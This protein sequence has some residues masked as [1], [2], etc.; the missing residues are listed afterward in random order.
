MPLFTPTP[1]A[2]TFAIPPS[3]V[4]IV[5]SASMTSASS[6]SVK[7]SL[8]ITPPAGT[9]AP[10]CAVPV[11]RQPHGHSVVTAVA[12]PAPQ[13]RST[14]SEAQLT[15]ASRHGSGLAGPGASKLHAAHVARAQLHRVQAMAVTWSV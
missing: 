6:G 15:D 7:S 1:D 3:S 12:S 8:V 10:Q 14:V 2:R 5:V 11:S 9:S 4:L 13:V